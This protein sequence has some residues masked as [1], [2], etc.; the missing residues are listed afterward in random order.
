MKETGIDMS[1]I[2][3]EMTH[4][5]EEHISYRCNFMDFVYS[6]RIINLKNTV[7]FFLFTS[8]RKNYLKTPQTSTILFDLLDIEKIYR[9]HVTYTHEA[10]TLQRR[11]Q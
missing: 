11:L 2:W 8:C 9:I 10:E 5:Q 4:K 7:C 3:D 6:N 1:Y